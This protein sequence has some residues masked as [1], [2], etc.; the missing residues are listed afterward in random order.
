MPKSV[1]LEYAELR[2]F[3][4]ALC[5]YLQ[6]LVPQFTFAEIVDELDRKPI[7]QR[8]KLRWMRMM[9]NDFLEMSRDLSPPQVAEAELLS[10]LLVRCRW[11]R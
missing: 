4:S 9:L 7:R 2:T 1:D 5:R 11:L 10:M 3:L 8:E 6:T